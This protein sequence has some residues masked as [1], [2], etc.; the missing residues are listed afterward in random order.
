MNRDEIVGIICELY[1]E[2]GVDE[3]G[4]DLEVLCRKMNVN[5]I[6]YS[7]YDS[8]KS[9]LLSV[10]EDA[11]CC[12]NVRSGK[13]EIFYNDEIRPK[14][15]I[16][17][18]IPHELGHVVMNHPIRLR[19]DPYCETEANLFGNELYVPQAFIIYYGFK[20]KSDL[21]ANFQITES[22]AKVLLD[23]VEKRKRYKP[24]L[25]KNEKRLIEI[26]ESNRNKKIDK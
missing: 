11:F 15:R 21:M 22:Y 4:F 5:L 10:S 3:F 16:K 13:Y 8:D 23:K 25:S 18:S 7:L 2:Y 1:E 19:R 9:I 14:G 12:Y 6:P 20:T 17:F 26:F 24:E